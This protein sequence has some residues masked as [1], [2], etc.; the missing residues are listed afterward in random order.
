MNVMFK[1]V[2]YLIFILWA[3]LYTYFSIQPVLIFHSQQAGFFHD[4]HYLE[5]YASKIGGMGTYISNYLFQ[6]FHSNLTGSFLIVLL[7]TILSLLVYSAL[8]KLSLNTGILFVLFPAAITIAQFQN[9]YFPLNILLQ[10]IAVALASLIYILF[11][12]KKN[13][14]FFIAFL[15]YVA[16]YYLFGSGTALIFGSAC[17][18]AN[19]IKTT[20]KSFVIN[21]LVFLLALGILPYIAYKFVF[22]FSLEQSYFYFLPQLPV[23]LS[24]S[25]SILVYLLI[26]SFPLLLIFS[27]FTS[28]IKANQKFQEINGYKG[29]QIAFFAII[30]AI[31]LGITYLT[32]DHHLRNI[33]LID[34][35]T[36]HQE[37]DKAIDL[38]EQNKQYDILINFNYNRAI[39]NS[40]KFL[41]K[42][43][44][45]PQLLGIN[46]LFPDGLG[47]PMYG[48]QA[49]EYYYDIDY[50]TRAQ[51]LAYG[52]LVLEPYNP[53]VLKQLVKTNLILGNIGAAQTFLDLLSANKQSTDF[54]SKYYP[55][56]KDTSLISLD[57]EFS[58]KIKY[59][60]NNFAMPADITD[61]IR[62]LI[63]SNTIPNRKA[64]EHL[65][66]CYLL[67]HNLGAFMNNLNASLQFY[68]QIP[69]IYE[70]A[71]LI[72]IYS[73]QSNKEMIKSIG[74]QS[75]ND[76]S[77]FM[78][79]L[80]VNNNDLQLAK[81]SLTDLTNTYMY[82]IKYL[83]PKATNLTVK[84]KK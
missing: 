55:Y 8:K 70:Q 10:A 20:A 69:E 75:K 13:Y 29:V 78:E 64:Y 43:F 57:A 47:T 83:S 30:M 6:F 24:Y 77:S 76:F 81:G 58:E 61:R 63:D 82:Y 36:Y 15:L 74:A 37:W 49:S 44:D 22:N 84:T 60:P 80:K 1:K 46:S 33:A 3:F 17:I 71:I 38:A 52:A 21:T 56:L 79:I 65:Q 12:N 5:F 19:S 32:R 62:D 41:D 66:M 16:M 26:I 18:I 51:H 27:I 25:K 31:F 34:Y 9:Y 53:R 14:R 50:I 45:Y 2:L 67:D 73:T 4:K 72:Y 23:T 42:F 68:K 39:D 35:Y 40:G 59:Q 11:L 7:L 28:K 48:I 54:C